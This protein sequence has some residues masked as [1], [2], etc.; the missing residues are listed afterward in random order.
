M[1]AVRSGKNTAVALGV[2][3][4]ETGNKALA[5]LVSKIKKWPQQRGCLSPDAD[6]MEP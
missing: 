1:A 5:E 4:E 2:P 6:E 3:S